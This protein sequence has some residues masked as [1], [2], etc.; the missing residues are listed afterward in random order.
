MDALLTTATG[1]PV[2]KLFQMGS[3]LPDPLVRIP[4]YA[5]SDGRLY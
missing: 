2:P 4:S 5:A 1:E 3:L